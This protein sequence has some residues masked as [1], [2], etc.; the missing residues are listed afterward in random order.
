MVLKLDTDEQYIEESGE[1]REVDEAHFRLYLLNTAGLRADTALALPGPL[2]SPIL[3]A[4]ATELVWVLPISCRE[5][6]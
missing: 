2:S 3:Q 1:W 5:V 4:P 6:S